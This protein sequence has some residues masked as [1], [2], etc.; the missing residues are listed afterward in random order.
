MKKLAGFTATRWLLLGLLLVANAAQAQTRPPIVE[1]LAKTYGLDS[2]GQV[3]AVRYTFNIQ[4]PALKLTLA[5]AWEWHPKTGEVSFESKDKDGKPVKVTYNRNQLNNAPAN[6][7][8]EVDPAVMN[9][10]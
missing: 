5:H 4:I 8:D 1:Q 10:N 3:D 7:K 2:W 9:D 6:V